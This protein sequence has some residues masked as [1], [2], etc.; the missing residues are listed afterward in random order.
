MAGRRRNGAASVGAGSVTMGRSCGR[1]ILL[2]RQCHI[3]DGACQPVLTLSAMNH[4]FRIFALLVLLALVACEIPQPPAHEAAATPPTL[5]LVPTATP[6]PTATAIPPPTVTLTATATLV[7]TATPT[8]EPRVTL[9]AV[10]DL[11]LARSLGRALEVDP[12]DTPFAAVRDLLRGADITVGNLECAIGT[13]GEPAPKAFTFRAPPAAAS[14]LADAGFDVL[15]L[16]NNHILDYGVP[17]LDETLAHL[18]AV[19]IVYA[20]AGRDAAAARRPA[21]VEVGGLRLAFLSYVHVPVEQGGFVT[22]SWAATDATPGVAWAS[23]ELVDEDV[24]TAL[25]GVDHVVVLLHSGYEGVEQPNEIQRAVARTAV[26][27]GASLVIGHHP[28]VLQRTERYG[29]GLI[30]YSLGNFVFD[31]FRDAGAESAILTLTFTRQG[32]SNPSWIPVVLVEGRPILV[33]G[34]QAEAIL[35]R[36]TV[37]L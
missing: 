4:C 31:G 22:E 12:A 32:V 37:A 36:L 30:V 33:E 28:H 11:M 9:V 15:S 2:S 27:A 8:P 26:D 35:A 34:A 3:V 29:T 7:P 10:G 13:A 21:V 18:D 5:T 19:G 1:R 25:P 14:S 24:R 16:A 20:G 6:T 23:P 17:A